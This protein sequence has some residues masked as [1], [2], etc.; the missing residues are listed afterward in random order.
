[1]FCEVLESYVGVLI[2]LFENL[3]LGFSI[4]FIINIFIANETSLVLP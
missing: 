3:S 1:M 2:D 4:S